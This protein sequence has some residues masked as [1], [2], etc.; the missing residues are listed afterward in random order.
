MHPEL[1]ELLGRDPHD[2][3]DSALRSVAERVGG[4]YRLTGGTPRNRGGYVPTPQQV[5]SI[6]GDVTREIGWPGARNLAFFSILRSTGARVNALRELDGSD[7]VEMPDGTLRLF[8]HEKGKAE[9]REVEL[10][11]SVSRMLR[12]YI[13]AFNRT[14]RVLGRGRP[15]RAGEPG[16]V[17]RGKSS[18]R[19]AYDDIRRVLASA[20]NHIGIEPITPHALRRAF[21]TEA[22]SALPRHIVAL[23]GG[24]RGLERLDDHYIH[25]R[26]P[27]IWDKLS[28][29]EH[30]PEQPATEEQHHATT[31]AVPPLR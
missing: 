14:A 8:L 10:G 4:G 28:R 12:D 7:C 25:P 27:T 11:H 6:L 26:T 16:P 2:V 13:D 5:R 19:W 18:Q 31:A 22:A 1:L 3:L 17:W 15:I 21:A 23:A 20:C 30:Y 9:P 24:W 29:D